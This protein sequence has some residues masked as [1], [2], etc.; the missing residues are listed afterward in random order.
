MPGDSVWGSPS[1]LGSGAWARDKTPPQPQQPEQW[2]GKWNLFPFPSLPS[3]FSPTSSPFLLLF[4]LLTNASW[5][6]TLSGV[7]PSCACQTPR[8]TNNVVTAWASMGLFLSVSIQDPWSS[9]FSSWVC[10]GPT[11]LSHVCGDLLGCSHVSWVGAGTGE[12]R[13]P[14]CGDFTLGSHTQTQRPLSFLFPP[15]GSSN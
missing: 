14:F 11:Q 10:D 7:V 1:L 13:S 3:L 8:E 5:A 15:G 9:P 12:A 4:T 2:P 6:P